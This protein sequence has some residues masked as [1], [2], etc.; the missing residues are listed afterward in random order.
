MG[1]VVLAGQTDVMAV[2]AGFGYFVASLGEARLVGLGAVGP[3]SCLSASV[4][5]KLRM[6]PVGVI[7]GLGRF[8]RLGGFDSCGLG[9]GAFCAEGARWRVR[10]CTAARCSRGFCWVG[11]S[12]LFDGGARRG[13]G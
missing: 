5:V 2:C 13:S 12:V 6:G 3:G 1:H 10:W 8:S 7:C 4:V 11:S 9:L